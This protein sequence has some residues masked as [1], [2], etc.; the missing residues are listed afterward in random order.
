[1]LKSIKGLNIVSWVPKRQLSLPPQ[2]T[3]VSSLSNK[4][5]CDDLGE[6]LLPEGKNGINNLEMEGF[7]GQWCHK[8]VDWWSYIKRDEIDRTASTVDG[9][10]LVSCSPRGVRG[11]AP[12]QSLKVCLKSDDKYRVGLVSG[13]WSGPKVLFEL[14]PQVWGGSLSDSLSGSTQGLDLKQRSCHLLACY[15]CVEC[16]TRC[17]EEC[18][19]CVCF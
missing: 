7:Q 1:M 10:V 6:D 4:M 16:W 18:F 13:S 12:R 11:V 9:D 17:H 14:W 3:C 15:G 19:P 2:G 5:L 8:N